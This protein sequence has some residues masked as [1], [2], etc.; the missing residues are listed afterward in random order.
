M[1]ALRLT[2]KTA[3][4]IDGQILK[5]LK[6]LGNPEPPLDLRLVRDLLD[7]DLGYYSS[8]DVGFLHETA[9]RILVAGKQILKRPSILLDAIRNSSLRALYL[10]DKKRILIDKDSP[11]LKHRWNQAHE[12]GHSI[13]PWHEPLMHG[14][15]D[16]T[17]T[18]ACQEQVEA[19]ANFA[20]GRLLFLGDRFSAE[21][22]SVNPS[23]AQVIDLSKR[24]G[25]TITSTLWRFV[26][27][28]RRDKAMVALVSGH[29]HSAMR[30]PT[31]DPAS[32]CRYFVG[33]GK[34]TS[35]FSHLSEMEVFSKVVS[36]CGRQK[37]GLLGKGQ[38]VLTDD[39][40]D[41]HLFDF[42]TFF[43]GY[44]ALTLGV[45]IGARPIT[46]AVSVF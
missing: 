25:N 36:Y 17:L 39:N 42:E 5:I 6:G 37:H 7:L 11:K 27:Q 8:T 9:S 43:N 10:P 14:D 29:P 33:S 34:F 41:P 13:I 26:E 22:S 20:G 23:M 44:E 19:E 32:P 28:A 15:T 30:A 3:L 24:Y 31:F 40:G 38:V 1:K 21:S 4:S 35:M 2:E 46:V 45:W 18:L 12:I 16:H